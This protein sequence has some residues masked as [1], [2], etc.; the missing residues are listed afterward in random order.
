MPKERNGGTNGLY[1]VGFARMGLAGI[2]ME[3]QEVANDIESE[4]QFV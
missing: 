2:S 1:F 4:L 3:A